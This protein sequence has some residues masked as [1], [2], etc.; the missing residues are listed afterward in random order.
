MSNSNPIG[1]GPYRFSEYLKDN[2]LVLERF[3]GYWRKKPEFHKVTFKFF[4]NYEN[5]LNNF[6]EGNADIIDII[7]PNDYDNLSKKNWLKIIPFTFST[8]TY[9]GFNFVENNPFLDNPKEQKAFEHSPLKSTSF[10]FR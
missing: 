6:L 2:Y 4:D 7:D 8:V 10:P 3:E 1:T 9:L 5:Q